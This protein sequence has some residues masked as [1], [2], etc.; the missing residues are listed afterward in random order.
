[1]SEFEMIMDRAGG[2]G[3][4]K[5]SK[6]FGKPCLKVRWS[7]GD[8]VPPASE[9]RAWLR[10]CKIHT[11]NVAGNRASKA[12]GIAEAVHDFLVAAIRGETPNE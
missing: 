2:D 7:P 9:C 1:M 8:P 11:L 3:R 5:E 10:R 12:P 4:V 6:W